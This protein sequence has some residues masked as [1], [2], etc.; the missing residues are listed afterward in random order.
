MPRLGSRLTS[1]LTKGS[2][3]N[4]G[5]PEFPLLLCKQG[6]HA[7]KTE[8]L[9]TFLLVEGVFQAIPDIY[10]LDQKQKRRTPVRLSFMSRG[11]ILRFEGP[12]AHA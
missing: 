9:F 1:S 12:P 11:S 2:R 3:A 10:T 6:I 4:C 8:C 7:P 5:P